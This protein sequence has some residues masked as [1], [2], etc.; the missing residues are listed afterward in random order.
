M[1]SLPGRDKHIVDLKPQI[2][3]VF[4]RDP[5]S[6]KRRNTSCFDS[7]APFQPFR[8]LSPEAGGRN[9]LQSSPQLG[10]REVSWDPQIH[11]KHM[12]KIIQHHLTDPFCGAAF[13]A[14][15]A[16]APSRMSALPL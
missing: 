12:D 13:V 10:Q 14:E 16:A 8:L 15:T 11:R 4:L 9:P 3:Q 1:S 7:Q 2:R 5:G 6:T